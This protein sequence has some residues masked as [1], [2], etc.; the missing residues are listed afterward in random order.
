MV[1]L[2]AGDGNQV[3]GERCHSRIKLLFL[4]EIALPLHGPQ[5]FR[6]PQAGRKPDASRAGGSG[7]RFKAVAKNSTASLLGA[8]GVQKP[9]QKTAQ[10]AL[11]LFQVDTEQRKAVA[12]N[13]TSCAST[14]LTVHVFF[15]AHQ[16]VLQNRCK[17]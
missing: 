2:K 15:R 14:S 9:L 3:F 17:K 8:L 7:K 11:A 10:R 1:S 5:V 13:S 4:A 16:K 12:K 6:P